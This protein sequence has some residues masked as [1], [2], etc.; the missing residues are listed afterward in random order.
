MT[1]EENDDSEISEEN[2]EPRKTILATRMYIGETDTSIQFDE[3][4]IYDKNSSVRCIK[5]SSE[6]FMGT[7]NNTPDIITTKS[8]LS[9]ALNSN[10][11]MNILMTKVCA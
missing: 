1:I 7:V 5:D 8:E 2:N 11:S 6:I 4:N 9:L 10:H 3:E